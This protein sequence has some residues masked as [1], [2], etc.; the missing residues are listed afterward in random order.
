MSTIVTRAGKGSPLTHNEVD[1][2]FNNLNSDKA[3][4]ANNL[5]DLTS[6][7]TART[8]LGLPASV[9][10]DTTNASNISS[11]TL[12]AAR[13]PSLAGDASSSAGSN[14][15]TLATVNSNTGSFGSAAL[16][17]IVTVNGKGLITAV[18]TAAN[19]QG[20]VTS[21]GGT[22]TVNG[23]TL[24]GT[25]TSSGNLTLGG[26][27]SG[28]SL[29]TQVT[30]NLPVTN[31]N[32]GTSASAST[33]WR[34]DGVWA[35]VSATTANNLAGG[36]LG[37]VPYQLLSGSTTFLAGNTTTTPQFLTST[38]VAGVATAPTY[39]G[40]TGSGN[41]VLATSP[42]LVTPA[43]GTPSALV[44]TN[45]TGTASGLSIGGNAATA[46]TATTA[47]NVSGTVAIAN[48]GTGATTRQNAMDALAGSVT[49]G[50]YLRGNGT[51]VLM[52]A[53][54]AADVPTLN[55]NTTGSSASCTG[56]SATATT[57][58]NQSGGTVS[59]TTGTFSGN[60]SF[61]SGYGS[62]V[63]AYGCRAWVNFNGTGTVAI[64]A[65]G[66]VTSITDNATG[67]YTVNFTTAMP[68]ANYATCSSGGNTTGNPADY[69]S[70]TSQ[71]STSA[72]RTRTYNSSGTG[73]DAAF[74]SLAAFR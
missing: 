33:Y 2:N 30:G 37:S 69:L 10:T 44:G 25:V 9:T 67:D 34:G 51:D 1:A 32:S 38:G 54:Q 36:A 24:T 4:K 53:I 42:T 58:T 52:S 70:S 13:L 65:S 60:L 8:N 64:R 50:Q 14:T 71:V 55:Q 22:G 40:S 72:T 74:Y 63:V 26:T 27:L 66:N 39:T 45:I 21:V 49:S 12:P 3:E 15:L 23:I 56:N 20:T 29:A 47:G 62:S 18:S 59:A 31:L 28:V 61:N 48:G 11:G 73:I 57:A 5:S 41:V 7:S 68:D 46:T 19:P 43:L 35:S 16:I 17:P 6:A